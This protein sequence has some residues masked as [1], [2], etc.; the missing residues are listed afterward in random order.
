MSEL[1]RQYRAMAATGLHFRGLTVLQHEEAIRGL[2]ERHRAVTLLDY[3]AGAGEAYDKPHQLHKRWG[4]PRP[5]LYDPAFKH[6]KLPAGKHHGVI[7]SDVLE[8][9]PEAAIDS[10]VRSLFGYANRFV[11]ASVCCRP[12]TKTF[13]DGT[14]LHITLRPYQWWHDTFTEH[15][16]KDREVEWVLVE[17]P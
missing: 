5:T 12:A 16:P 6:N 8:H 15:A 1:L 13:S 3:G 17:T 9:V 7:C 4:V 11:F 10:L 14:N 2:I